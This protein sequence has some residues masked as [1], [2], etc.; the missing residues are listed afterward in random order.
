MPQRTAS[1]VNNLIR[2]SGGIAVLELPSNPN[3]LRD[4]LANERTFL[5]WLRTG[6]TIIA[7]GFVVAKFGI[8]LREIRGG[9]AASNVPELTARLGAV[10]GVALVIAGI[11]T[12]LFAM[13]RFLRIRDDLEHS[14][15]RFSPLLDIVTAVMVGGIAVVMA[16]YL[17]ITS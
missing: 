4:H 12:I 7:L 8:L 10:V 5:A 13:I 9:A 2:Y 16:I 6:I 3:L 15:V 14:V 11:L 17:V 1:I